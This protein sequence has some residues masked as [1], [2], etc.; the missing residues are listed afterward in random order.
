MPHEKA[1]KQNKKDKEP[2]DE[3][4][5]R[6]TG[7]DI[8]LCQNCKIGHLETISHIRKTICNTQPNILIHH[9]I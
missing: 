5:M 7:I 8:N 2:I 3:L 9:D 4:M 1:P 6:I